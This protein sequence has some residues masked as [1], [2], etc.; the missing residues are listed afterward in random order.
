MQ[1][2]A[3]VRSVRR[4]IAEACRVIGLSDVDS[5]RIGLVV[6]ELGRTMLSMMPGSSIGMLVEGDDRIERIVLTF[7]HHA[8]VEHLLSNLKYFD[9]VKIESAHN[10]QLLLA[11]KNI[12]GKGRYCDDELIDALK[13]QLSQLTRTELV[14]ELRVHQAHLRRQDL[15]PP[16]RGLR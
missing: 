8:Q 5:T 11:S 4:N 1:N 2:I 3:S 15:A 13:E 10:N 16:G 14:E 9:T 12:P 6:S 7:P